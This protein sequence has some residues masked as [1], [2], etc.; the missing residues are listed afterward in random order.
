MQKVVDANARSGALRNEG[1]TS[2]YKQWIL[3][4]EILLRRWE[5]ILSLI[6]ANAAGIGTMCCD[7]GTIR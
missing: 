5:I 4:W 6:D 1:G 2:C 3:R 7:C